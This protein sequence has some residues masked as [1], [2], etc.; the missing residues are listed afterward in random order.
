M[1]KRFLTLIFSIFL[2]FVLSELNILSV[3]G[4]SPEEP[5]GELRV[6]VPSLL[7]ET[8]DPYRAPPARKFYT[9]LMY[10]YLIGINEKMELDPQGGVAYKWEESSD[11]MKWTYY[12]RDGLKFHDGTPVTME[13]IKYSMETVLDEKNIVG[14]WELNPYVKGF[15]IVPPQQAGGS[16]E[17][18]VDF[19]ALLCVSRW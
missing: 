2:F 13:D 14:P 8:M 3:W 1:M 19:D 5:L 10:D 17:E 11:H 16:Y 9:E 12:I 15:E 4:A 18:A 6:G 7:T